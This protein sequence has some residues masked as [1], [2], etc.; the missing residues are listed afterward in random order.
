MIVVGL[1]DSDSYLKWTAGTLDRI[2]PDAERELIV[3][4]NPVMPSAQ[5]RRAALESTSWRARDPRVLSVDDAVAA[6]RALGADAVLVGMRGPTAALVLGML[7]D[8]VAGAPRPVL[9]SGLPGIAVPATRKALVYRAQADLMLVHSRRERLDFEERSA[10]LGSGHRF[11]L[12]SLPFLERHR[13]AGDDVVLAA[14]ALVPRTRSERQHLVDQWVRAARAQPDR[15]FV[16]KVRAMGGERQTHDDRWPLE[17]LLDRVVERPSNLIVRGGSMTAT[18]DQAGALVSVSSTALVEAVARGIPAVALDDYGV[19]D[20]LINTVFADSGLL[21]S[22]DDVIAGRFREAT[23]E[24]RRSNYLHDDTDADAR[25]ALEELVATRQSQGL[26]HRPAL[27]STAGGALR[28][29]WDRRSAL[30]SYDH[31]PLGTAAMIVG[32]PL[33][34]VVRARRRLLDAVR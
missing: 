19:G 27:R 21:G 33:R 13:S 24:W 6:V 2:A 16:L 18:L 20:E 4:E 32:S 14:Q 23:G 11:A 5:Q 7:A 25:D 28:R 34:A 17:A 31:S 15:R 9:V 29:A 8:D 26:A 30:G 1:A 22:T 10:T 3:I 12:T